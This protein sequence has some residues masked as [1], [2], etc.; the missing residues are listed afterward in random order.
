MAKKLVYEDTKIAQNKD[1]KSAIPTPN[2]SA[3]KDGHHQRHG[4]KKGMA[5]PPPVRR[6][7]VRRPV[8]AHAIPID[9]FQ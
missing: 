2:R 5:F 6:D 3:N 9:P 4:L 1:F 8:A 7:S